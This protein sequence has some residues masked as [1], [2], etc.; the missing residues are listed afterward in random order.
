MQER[1][2]EPQDMGPRAGGLHASAS[3]KK[4]GRRVRYGYGVSA[5]PPGGMAGVT[6]VPLAVAVE[7]IMKN[8]IRQRGV[9]APEACIEPLPFFHRYVK[10]CVTPPE[11]VAH[12]LYEIVEEI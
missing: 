1:P 5:V 7:M 3:G 10:Y 4:G 11:R 12:A 2:D 9:L 8:E 6:G